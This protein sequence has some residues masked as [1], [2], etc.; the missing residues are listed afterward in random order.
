MRYDGHGS[1]IDLSGTSAEPD[2]AEAGGLFHRQ[3]RC[4][5]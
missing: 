2:G 4:L 5:W 3:D 1:G